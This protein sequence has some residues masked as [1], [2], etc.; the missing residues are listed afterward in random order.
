MR[1]FADGSWVTPASCRWTASCAS[2]AIGAAQ[3]GAHPPK[4]EELHKTDPLDGFD[5][6][7]WCLSLSYFLSIRDQRA[8]FW[9]PSHGFGLT[10]E[11]GWAEVTRERVRWLGDKRIVDD[12]LG[13]YDEW[14]SLGRPSL[15][16]YE[17]TF[18]PHTDRSE[19]APAD[20]GLYVDR[21]LFRQRVTMRH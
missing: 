6:S 12:L 19:E 4:N 3:D 7:T 18:E 17:M 14:C 11:S 15:E 2:T 1:P 5:F 9:S 16:N 20:D 10:A 8:T 13:L 21:P